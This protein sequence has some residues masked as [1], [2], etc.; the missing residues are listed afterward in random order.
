M[1]FVQLLRRAKRGF[2]FLTSIYKE[3]IT[4]EEQSPF[5]QTRERGSATLLTRTRKENM[6]FCP[7]WSSTFLITC[8]QGILAELSSADQ[9]STPLALTAGLGA[10]FVNYE[11]EN[12]SSYTNVAAQITTI[13]WEKSWRG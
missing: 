11:K 13:E 3:I 4:T 6:W 1:S 5:E 12:S 9:D 10:I 2:V 7:L 8:L